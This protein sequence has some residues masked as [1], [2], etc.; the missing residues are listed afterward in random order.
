LLLNARIVDAVTNHVPL[1]HCWPASGK[2]TLHP[3]RILAKDGMKQIDEM[4]VRMM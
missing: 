2:W 4:L 1:L 3:A